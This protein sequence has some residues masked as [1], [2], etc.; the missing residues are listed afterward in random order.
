MTAAAFDGLPLRSRG[1]ALLLFLA[2]LATAAPL[3]KG[4][5]R[6]LPLMALE[7]AALALLFVLFAARREPVPA[8]GAVSPALAIGVGILLVYP[9]LQLVPLPGTLWA[10]LPGHEPYAAIV[11]RFGA[12]PPAWRTVSLLPARTIA[13]WL[14]LLPPLAC[15]LGMLSLSQSNATRLLVWMSVVAGVEGV[16]GLMQAGAGDMLSFAERERLASNAATGTFVN[17]NHLAAMLAMM[18]PVMVALLIRRIR[19]GHLERR[20][21]APGESAAQTALLA[22]SAL[23]VLTCLV[24]TRSR[25]GIATAAIAL[26]LLFIAV[27]C[28]RR[29]VAASAPRRGAAWIVAAVAATGVAIAA[30]LAAVSGAPL[31]R[32]LTPEAVSLDLSGRI[33][34]YTTTLRAALEFLPFGSGLGTFA[35]VYPRF[36]PVT[37]P[38]TVSGFVNHAHN[39]YLE[40]FM[41][42]GIAA[43]LVVLLLLRA[44]LGRLWRLLRDDDG[45][46]FTLLQL[47]AGLGMFATML[48]SALDFPLHMPG[49]A[50]WFALLAG[51]LFHARAPQYETR[52]DALAAVEPVRLS[53]SG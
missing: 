20:A 18:L 52:R 44:Y 8:S 42:I 31:A 51:V 2:V 19:P 46:G 10:G 34:M 38:V 14:A 53:P 41:E 22:C 17:K 45:R 47:A 4:G 50:M 3:Y 48:H 9:I 16:L 29:S 39:D 6:P 25:A 7:L 21:P 13:S 33:A 49:N 36:Q 30:A 35:D 24:F 12:T 1:V 32:R 11:E 5:N 23:V 26:A 27:A 15:L 43:P 37:G 28:A 40:S